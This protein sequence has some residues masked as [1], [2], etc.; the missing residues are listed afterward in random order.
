[1]EIL[2]LSFFRQSHYVPIEVSFGQFFYMSIE[3]FYFLHNK[4]INGGRVNSVNSLQDSAVHHI[5]P[6]YDPRGQ[7]DFSMPFSWGWCGN[8][9]RGF[10]I[11]VWVLLSHFWGYFCLM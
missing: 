2:I 8:T 10:T 9:H 5:C 4:A 6:T 3:H 1:M 11:R 7:V